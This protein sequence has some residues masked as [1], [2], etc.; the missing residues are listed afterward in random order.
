MPSGRYLVGLRKSTEG[1]MESTPA[2]DMI[3]KVL[4]L[5]F[6]CLQHRCTLIGQP[7]QT[8]PASRRAR[9]DQDPPPAIAKRGWR[10]HHIGIPTS[11]PR[12]GERHLA[13]LKLFVSG[14]QTSEFGIEWMRFE[15]DCPVS[16]LVRTVPHIAFQVDDLERAIRGRSLLGGISSPAKG[17]RVAMIV[18]NGAP[19]EL[20]EFQPDSRSPGQGRRGRR[21]RGS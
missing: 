21:T 14:F 6:C 17:V 3:V 10:Y 15:P 5:G 19:I 18:E 4:Y 16:E 8:K 20:I 7:M 1:R 11:T 9:R 2:L 12:E 13:E